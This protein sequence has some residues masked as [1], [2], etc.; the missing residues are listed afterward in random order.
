VIHE[1]YTKYNQQY[2]LLLLVAQQFYLN[3]K[4]LLVAVLFI[5]EV[6]LEVT[7]RDIDSQVAFNYHKYII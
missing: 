1:I 3:T 4:L 6:R 2:E 7:G 5:V